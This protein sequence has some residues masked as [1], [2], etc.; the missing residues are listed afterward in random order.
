[1]FSGCVLHGKNMDYSFTGKVEIELDGEYQDFTNDDFIRLAGAPDGAKLIVKDYD[2]YT[3]HDFFEDPIWQ[4]IRYDEDD[5]ISLYFYTRLLVLKSEYHN[6]KF[7]TQ[8]LQNQIKK[9]TE[10]GLMTF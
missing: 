10:L 8:M 5:N 6:Q 3:E 9:A 7:V 2:L 1:M 4:Q